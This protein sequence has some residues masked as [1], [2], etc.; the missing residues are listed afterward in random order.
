[1]QISLSKQG[2]VT[3]L[4]IAGDVDASNYTNVIDKAQ[5]LYDEGARDLLIDLDKVPYISSAGLMAL[6]SVAQIFAGQSMQAKD[7][8]RP[9]FRAINPQQDV[10]A[11]AHVKLL[12]PQPSVMQVLDVV[13]L[14]AFFEMFSDLETAV[15][16]F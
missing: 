5:Q 13:G 2:K 9:S 6:H 11:R 7:G 8:R 14:S 16:S 15:T 4:H 3:I 10:S 1:M 12:S